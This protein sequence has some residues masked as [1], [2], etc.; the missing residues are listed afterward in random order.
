MLLVLTLHFIHPLGAG[1]TCLL[2]L[3]LYLCVCLSFSPPTS[4]SLHLLTTFDQFGCLPVLSGCRNLCQLT[5]RSSESL[6]VVTYFVH[7]QQA[8]LVV[9]P[10]P[11][12][13]LFFSFLYQLSRPCF[14]MFPLLTFLQVFHAILHHHHWCRKKLLAGSMLRNAD[15]RETTHPSL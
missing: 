14:Y 4:S 10:L 9:P 11:F 2:S 5:P 15:R 8:A 7:H 1:D 6:T 3:F 12:F 13:F